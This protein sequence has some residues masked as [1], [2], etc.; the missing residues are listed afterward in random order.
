[1]WYEVFSPRSFDNKSIG[2]II[3]LENT[4]IGRTIETSLYDFTN[5]F[6][7]INLKVKFRIVSA[8]HEAKTA[9]SVLCGHEFSNDYVRSL[10]GRGT[11]KIQTIINLT[12]KDN[13]VFRVTTVC[14]TIKRARSSQQILVRKIMREILKEFAQSLNHEKFVRG[15]IYGE[16][17]HQIRRIA[18]TIYPLSS[19]TVVKSKLL[20]IPEGGEDKEVPDDDFEIV[21]VEVQ[22][23]RK[24]EI[25]RTERINV[26]KL[27]RK[28]HQR[29]TAP[30]PAKVEAKK[31][32]PEKDAEE[33]KEE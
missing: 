18:K 13:Y 6:R 22:R 5:N 10:I 25:R 20:S 3:G 33:K 24:S 19:S 32:E 26:K 27:T 23:S 4:I 2:E 30:A 16:F 1:N 17:Q 9:Q 31:A 15:M 11:S 28:T 12:T 14:T 21:E 8:N 29:N 7:D